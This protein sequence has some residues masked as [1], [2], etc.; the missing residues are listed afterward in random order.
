MS[1]PFGRYAPSEGLSGFAASPLEECSFEVFNAHTRVYFAPAPFQKRIYDECAFATE[2]A[3]AQ[4]NTTWR[5]PEA[6]VGEAYWD[7]I[8]RLS[9]W[10]KTGPGVIPTG[11]VPLCLK[12]AQH[13]GIPI[14]INDQR[15][16]PL[17]GVPD[18]HTPVVDRDYQL[19]AVKL[20]LEKGRG[21]FDMPP[22]SGKT[23]VL[24]EVQ[25]RLALPMIWIASTKNIV[26]QTVKVLEGVFGKNYAAELVGTKWK[27]LAH[28][29]VIVC[30]AA[31]AAALTPE[32]Y[33]TRDIIGIDEFH[34]GAS[35]QIRKVSTMCPNQPQ[36]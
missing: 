35:A 5:P 14:H 17:E 20:A 19:E 15:E 12:L 6:Q 29:R 34:H 11:L 13:F 22:R 8:I 1:Q 4:Q 9:R 21:V 24:I 3:L 7:G 31:T 28:I 33:A 30:T 32:F 23:R 27:P 16:R 26:K 36:A 2:T 18:L 25:R 10:P